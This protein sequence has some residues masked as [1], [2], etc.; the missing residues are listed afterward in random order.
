M[1]QHLKRP[2]TGVVGRISI[3]GGETGVS[4]L[5]G[6]EQNGASAASQLP[7]VLAVLVTIG[8]VVPLYDPNSIG[9]LY[10]RQSAQVEGIGLGGSVNMSGNRPSLVPGESSTLLPA[11]ADPLAYALV[12][13]LYDPY[14]WCY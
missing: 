7:D 9:S 4:A 3:G 5:G 1:W 6:I 14:L 10:Q 8:P 2:S 11:T 13:V 12:L